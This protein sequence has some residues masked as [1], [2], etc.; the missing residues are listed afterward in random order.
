MSNPATAAP[1]QP[2]SLGI[3]DTHG[4]ASDATTI[5]WLARLTTPTTAADIAERDMKLMAATGRWRPGT[6]DPDELVP[7]DVPIIRSIPLATLVGDWVEATRRWQM[8][9]GSQ[10]D[11]LSQSAVALGAQVGALTAGA[12]H[13]IDA[14]T[15]V[16]ILDSTPPEPD[17]LDGL[18]LPADATLVAFG[19]ELPIPIDDGVWP[20]S[21]VDGT[22]PSPRTGSPWGPL[23]AEEAL[24]ARGGALAGAVL[25]NHPDTGTFA[26]MVAWLVSINP[27]PNHPQELFR[28]DRQRTVMIASR[29]KMIWRHLADNLAATVGWMDWTRPDPLDL[30]DHNSRQWRKAIKRSQFRKR[31]PHG[32]AADVNVI[33]V[34]ANQPPTATTASG[35]GEAS[36]RT[37]STHLRTGHWRRVRV[38]ERDDTGTIVGDT[39]TAPE[40]RDGQWRYEGRWIAPTVVNPG[41]TRPAAQVWRLPTGGRSGEVV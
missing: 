14:A 37:T 41:H 9:T 27:D 20:S 35:T 38:A 7:G 21:W 19:R 32:A 5:S 8:A 11:R 33:D 1:G 26:D 16:G 40:E 39:R 13:Y 12:L 23:G 10:R 2:T 25:F 17:D 31:E 28:K 29:Q 24:L 36:G 18:R 15:A 22:M 3:A 4:L 34:P 30:P 6:D